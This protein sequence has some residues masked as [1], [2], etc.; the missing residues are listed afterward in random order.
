MLHL[1]NG[2]QGKVERTLVH[3]DRALSCL[4]VADVLPLNACRAVPIAFHQ[5]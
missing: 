4:L 1:S 3:T 2:W 5:G